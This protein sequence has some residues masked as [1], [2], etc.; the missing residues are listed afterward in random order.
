ML[1]SICRQSVYFISI[2]VL[3]TCRNPTCIGHCLIFQYEKIQDGN[4]VYYATVNTLN[5]VTRQ[6]LSDQ[7]L[8]INSEQESEPANS[9]NQ[10]SGDVEL[11]A[12][13][14]CVA[15]EVVEPIEEQPPITGSCYV[16]THVLKS[17]I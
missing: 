1:R 13:D 8:V 9:S 14:D 11:D 12:D 5:D 17:K 7:P 2:F 4:D 16:H 10:D 15:P 6:A 3:F